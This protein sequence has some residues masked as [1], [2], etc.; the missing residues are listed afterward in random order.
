M[1]LRLFVFLF[2][3]QLFAGTSQSIVGNNKISSDKPPAVRFP[4]RHI[5][6]Q[7]G[8]LDQK[9]WDIEASFGVLVNFNAAVFTKPVYVDSNYQIHPGLFKSWNWNYKNKS[10]TFKLDLSKK[11][12]ANRR[13]RLKDIEFAFLKSFLSNSGDYVSKHLYDIVG[14]RE[15]KRG[16]KFYSGMCK[17]IKL[18]GEDTI[19][20][21]LNKNNPEFVYLLEEVLPVIA[22]I[23]DFKEDLFS[24]KGIPRGSG[25]YFVQWS[26]SSD[27]AVRLLRKIINKNVLNKTYYPLSI[28]FINKGAPRKNKVDL[29]VEAGTSG[30]REVEG[31]TTQLSKIPNGI[32]S[33]EFN[34]KTSLGRNK[35]FRRAVSLAIDREKIFKNYIQMKQTHELIPSAYLGRSNKMFEKNKSIAKAIV[36]EHF[37]KVSSPKKPIEAIYHNNPG[38]PKKRY[39]IEIER[40]LRDVGLYVDFKGTQEV[41]FEG[42]KNQVLKEVGYGVSFTDPLGCFIAYLAMDKNDSTVVYK[43]ESKVAVDYFNKAKTSTDRNVKA[44]YIRKLSEFFQKN[45]IVIPLAE[46]KSIFAYGRRIKS[47]DIE[48]RNSSIDFDKVI[49]R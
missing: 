4:N 11:F 10:F 47:I 42:N 35:L 1:I 5:T 7:A 45:Y 26:S 43:G 14:T 21:Y 16:Q 29:A 34:Y 3:Y 32:N 36:K 37:S 17:G 12:D 15:L 40:Q 38:K 30:I 44:N 48:H 25:N 2:F 23:E 27:S 22:P 13:V 33:L 8:Q 46:S 20:V 9:P 19:I 41:V 49:L 31:Y 18:E 6:F 39:I 28:D 24:F